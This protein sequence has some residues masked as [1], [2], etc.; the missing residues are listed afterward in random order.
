[1]P[2]PTDEDVEHLCQRIARR[3][4][5]L[6]ATDDE[7]LW[8]EDE[9]A[10]MASVQAEAVRAPVRRPHFFDDIPQP[11]ARGHTPLTA[12]Y[13]GFSLHAGLWVEAK[14][15]QKLERLLRYGSRPPFAQKRLSVTPSGKVRLKLRKP[16]YT[17][18]TELVLDPKAFLRRLFA[19]IPPPR[20]PLTRYHGIFSGHHRL[21]KKLAA[22]L[23]KPPSPVPRDTDTEVPL[24]E[25]EKLPASAARLSYARLL[26]SAAFSQTTSGAANTAAASYASWLASTTQ[27]L[28]PKS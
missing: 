23:P 24:P 9:D 8:V 25:D 28:S 18:Q 16:Y 12:Q 1:L 17:G 11:K 20:W 26:S 6:C 7:E 4:T 27:M 22:L 2:S 3:T 5:K 19:I 15:R 14:R 13:K 21:R 10:V